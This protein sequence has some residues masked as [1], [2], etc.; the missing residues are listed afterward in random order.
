MRK[1]SGAVL[2]RTGQDEHVAVR[3]RIP[4]AV[5]IGG[6]NARWPRRCPGASNTL[7]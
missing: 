4:V 2:N 3:E 7:P 1:W 5:G 6:E